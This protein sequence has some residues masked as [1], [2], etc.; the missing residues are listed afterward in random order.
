MAADAGSTARTTG[1]DSAGNKHSG[2]DEPA[3][4]PKRGSGGDGGAGKN[5]RQRDGHDR[6]QDDDEAPASG[7]GR[8]AAGRLATK[9][10]EFKLLQYSLLTAHFLCGRPYAASPVHSTMSMLV[11]LH[12]SLYPCCIAGGGQPLCGASCKKM[13]I[14]EV[15][16]PSS[17]GS[18]S[19]TGSSNRR[20]SS[21]SGS[22]ADSSGDP[23]AKC[24]ESP[25]TGEMELIF[26]LS[27]Q[28]RRTLWDL[29]GGKSSAAQVKV[30]ASV[31]LAACT[32]A[33][34]TCV[35][36]CQ[37]QGQVEGLPAA[38][39]Q[40]VQLELGGCGS[41]MEVDLCSAEASKAA[42]RTV[43]TDTTDITWYRCGIYLLAYF[44]RYQCKSKCLCLPQRLLFGMPFW[45]RS[46]LAVSHA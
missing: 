31:Q 25:S 23:I 4:K 33:G 26:S 15:A 21:S 46:E 39:V 40:L 38:A 6:K 12:P 30:T 42:F 29:F 43:S 36:V 34:Q 8:V 11:K 37:L 9:L 18:S 20:S 44:S 14:E 24:S 19:S 3:D 13:R 27:E 28:Q 1:G 5:G 17:S 35:K 22:H 7:S 16:R 45:M 10:S 41:R 32:E 2:T